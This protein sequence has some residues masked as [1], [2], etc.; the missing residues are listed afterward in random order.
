M[1]GAAKRHL[2]YIK[3]PFYLQFASEYRSHLG[4]AVKG[5]LAA[6]KLQVSHIV[7]EVQL[8]ILV[9]QQPQFGILLKPACHQLPQ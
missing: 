3:R 8:S 6:V 7:E 1:C 5:P 9:Q 2:Q 4:E